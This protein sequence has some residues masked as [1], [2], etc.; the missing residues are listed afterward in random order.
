[1][2]RHWLTWATTGLAVNGN[3]KVN[4]KKTG[5]L[6]AGEREAERQAL[7]AL[8]GSFRAEKET[9]LES[10]LDNPRVRHKIGTAIGRSLMRTN[11]PGDRA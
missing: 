9:L 7:R 5:A 2:L 11:W 1:M 4:D 6:S 3:R 8:L 10:A